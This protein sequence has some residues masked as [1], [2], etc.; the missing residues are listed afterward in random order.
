M[1]WI[2]IKDRMPENNQ[3][4]LLYFDCPREGHLHR[5][6]SSDPCSQ[7]IMGIYYDDDVW[8]G[9]VGLGGDFSTRQEPYITHWMPL[10]E[11][12]SDERD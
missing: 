8:G 9:M 2:S 10:P 3:H 1:K 7:V 6:I 4:V 11:R 5:M 12:P